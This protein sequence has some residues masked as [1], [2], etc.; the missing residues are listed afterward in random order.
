MPRS[1]GA[2]MG[3]GEA[4]TE[5]VRDAVPIH[6]RLFNSYGPTETT[7]SCTKLNLNKNNFKKYCN[8]TASIGKSIKGMKIKLL[9]FS[10]NE[11]KN[12]EILISGPQVFN[13]YL[14]NEKLS[15]KKFINIDDKI[16]FKTGDIVEVINKNIYFKKRMDAQVKIKG[17][18]VELDEIDGFIRKYG[19][20]QTKTF[21][22]NLKLIS[23]IVYKKNLIPKLKKYLKLVL[24]VYMLPSDIINLKSFPKNHNDKIDIKKLENYLNIYEK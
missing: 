16:Y 6:C 4:M 23:F 15:N 12:L 24:P 17:Y 21:Y 10:K 18:R 19:I 22:K 13:G 2:V 20:Q 9:K 8:G 1:I 14:N 11:E 3:G 5:R 7:V